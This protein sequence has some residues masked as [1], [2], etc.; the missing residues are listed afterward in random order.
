M[1][2][3]KAMIGYF[4]GNAVRV[5]SVDRNGEPDRLGEMLALFY[6]DDEQAKAL[7]NLGNIYVVDS[8]I[9]PPNGVR[10]SFEH[11]ASEVN[12]Q[13][14]VTIAYH[15]DRGDEYHQIQTPVAKLRDAVSFM[16]SFDTAYIYIYDE[17]SGRW[18]F[19]EHEGNG[20]ELLAEYVDAEPNEKD[21]LYDVERAE[22]EAR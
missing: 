17:P 11:P 22:R 6:E 15:R 21:E 9:A 16:L 12:W 13:I 2:D 14:K 19:R 5:V 10:H 8:M 18:Y 1:T 7:L 3:T 4:D 20:I